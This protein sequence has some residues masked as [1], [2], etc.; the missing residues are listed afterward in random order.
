M[1]TMQFILPKYRQEII[2]KI[3]NDLNWG[4]SF[5]LFEKIRG[6]DARFQDIFNF[7]YFDFKKRIN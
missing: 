6:S 3:Y 1:Y 5:L 4:G 7:L 2:N